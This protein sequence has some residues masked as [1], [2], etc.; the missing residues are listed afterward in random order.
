MYHTTG[1]S[2][3]QIVGIAA[4]VNGL[5]PYTPPAR[6]PRPRLG[7]YNQIC[8]TLTCLR[9]NHVQAE[10]GEYYGVSQPTVSK[11][12]AATIPKIVEAY[13]H[14]IP[15]VEDLGPSKQLIIDGTLLPCWSW[16]DR[17]ELYSG[18][19][20][21]TGHNV[22]VA[23]SLEGRLEWVSDPLPGSTHDAAALRASGLLDTP[24][25]PLHIGD[26]GYI[27]LGMLTP[28]RK[29]PGQE[30]LH[31]NDKEFNRQIGQ[32]RYKIEQV[33]ANLKTW[34]AIFVDYRRPARTFPQA[35]TAILA[36]E[37]LRQN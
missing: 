9:R 34:R 25:P 35:L 31:P 20:H 13:G 27:G 15:A 32:L 5:F 22:Q 4:R 29:L 1:F 21:T 19:H 2:R 23:C 26:K 10:V 37:F 7:L 6:G 33:I 17:P 24:N 28:I 14:L 8:V 11:I 36:L 16:A 3:D 12:V 30:H 18:K